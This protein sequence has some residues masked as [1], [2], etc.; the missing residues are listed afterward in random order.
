MDIMSSL[1]E[2]KNRIIRTKMMIMIPGTSFL[3]VIPEKSPILK[4][5][6]KIEREGLKEIKASEKAPNKAF[7]ATPARITVLLPCPIFIESKI[8]IMTARK[9]PVNAIAEREKPP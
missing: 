4:S 7:S 3:Y 9:A 2:R 6:V 1:S 8:N 5:D